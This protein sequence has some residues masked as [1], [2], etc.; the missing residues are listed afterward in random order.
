MGVHFNL[1]E[2]KVYQRTY[3]VII[4]IWVTDLQKLVVVREPAKQ[5]GPED[6]VWAK[7]PGG[8]VRLYEPF[9]VAAR[10]EGQSEAGMGKGVTI[11]E[12]APVTE[13]ARTWLIRQTREGERLHQ[14]IYMFVQIDSRQLYDVEAVGDQGELWSLADLGI[15][16]TEEFH[17]QQAPVIQAAMVQ[18][19]ANTH[20]A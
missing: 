20:T 14:L 9:A 12:S 10:R 7:L 18:G 16:F 6:K 19:L 11:P 15:I 1:D 3:A 4:F 17:P 2:S 5:R 13:F 8:E